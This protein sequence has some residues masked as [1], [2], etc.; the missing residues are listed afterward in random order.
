MKLSVDSTI[1]GIGSAS[2]IAT[3]AEGDVVATPERMREVDDRDYLLQGI[4]P[5]LRRNPDGTAIP[6][7]PRALAGVSVAPGAGSASPSDT[8]GKPDTAKDTAKPA[9]HRTRSDGAPP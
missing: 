5:P 9:K 7:V 4:A 8:P 3:P 1:S 2:A 6:P